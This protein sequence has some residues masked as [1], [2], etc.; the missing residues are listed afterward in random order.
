MNKKNDVYD[1]FDDEDTDKTDTP[2]TWEIDSE[3]DGEEE[4][5]KREEN[6]TKARE[7]TPNP[8]AVRGAGLFYFQKFFLADFY[9]HS[10]G[11]FKVRVVY[12]LLVRFDSPS[13]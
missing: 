10:S 1:S 12:P 7:W 6:K 8:R 4:E 5:E 3:E 2:E 13:P 9:H 11:R